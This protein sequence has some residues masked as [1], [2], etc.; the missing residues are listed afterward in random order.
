MEKDSVRLRY[1]TASVHNRIPIFR[2]NVVTLSGR[3]EV[4]FFFSNWPPLTIWTPGCFETSW[5][6]YAAKQRHIP[7]EGEASSTSLSKRQN[8]HKCGNAKSL[9]VPIGYFIMK[10]L[11]LFIIHCTLFS[12]DLRA[13]YGFLV[14]ARLTALKFHLLMWERKW[15]NIICCNS[16][17]NL[18]GEFNVGSYPFGTPT[19]CMRLTLTDLQLF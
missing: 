16:Q 15:S 18:S 7:E 2:D 12:V 6:D 8:A 5:S 19:V 14:F 4:S 10:S 13:G 9:K 11:R 3:T 17:Q 1:D